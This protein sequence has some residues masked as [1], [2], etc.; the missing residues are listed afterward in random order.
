MD[1][2]KSDYPIYSSPVS[3]HSG[4]ATN[5]T[6][7]RT[8]PQTYPQKYPQTNLL[9]LEA[10]F[11][12]QLKIGQQLKLLVVKLTDY[13]AILEILGYKTQVRTSDKALLNVG[14]RLKA[15]IT[16]LEPMIQLKVLSVNENQDTKIQSLINSALRQTMPAQLP[17][18]NLLESIQLITRTSI[19]AN[20]ALQAIKDAFIQSIPPLEA[21]EE[22]DVLPEIFK[23]SGIFSEHLLQKVITEASQIQSFPNNDLKIALLRLATKLRSLNTVNMDSK[24]SSIAPTKLNSKPTTPFETYN[25]NS[26]QQS[27]KINTEGLRNLHTTNQTVNT[28]PVA[29]SYTQEQLIDKLLKQADGA[30]ARIQTLQL[31]HLQPNEI[32]KPGWLFELPIRTDSL[33]DNISIYIEP[34]SSNT[35]N[36]K[37]TIPWKVILKFNIKELGA[38]QAHITMQGTKVSVNFWVDNKSTSSLFSEHLDK[39]GSQLNKA[40]LESGKLNCHCDTPP[41]QPEPLQNQVINETS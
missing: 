10:N 32:Q 41:K 31:Q 14:Q 6:N 25:L 17:I 3:K 40:G 27:K 16:S 7:P 5:L 20:S 30:I 19:P 36:D 18:K 15:Q 23:R 39:L 9:D 22:A 34:D 33:L 37:Y 35:D 1:I 38:I 26:I 28:K 29:A 21:F 13:D 2:K 12:G 11:A 8:N 24:G 4:D